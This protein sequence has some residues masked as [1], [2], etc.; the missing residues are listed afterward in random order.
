MLNL[1][2]NIFGIIFN[3][4]SM[5]LLYLLFFISS[6]VSASPCSTLYLKNKDNDMCIFTKG[7]YD[8]SI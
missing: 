6:T 4:L 3:I 8:N 2:P 5:K 7:S 1:R